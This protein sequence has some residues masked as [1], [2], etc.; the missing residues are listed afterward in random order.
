MK[1]AAFES[2]EK[3]KAKGMKGLNYAIE[4][5]S[6]ERNSNL[7]CKVIKQRLIMC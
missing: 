6:K 5:F 2:S 7:L 1:R 3:L 4:V